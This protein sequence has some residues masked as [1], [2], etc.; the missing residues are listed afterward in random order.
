M[1]QITLYHV[2][3]ACSFV[4]HALLHHLGIAFKA[5]EMKFRA[6]DNGLE[7]ADGS[8]SN[9]EY[10]KINPAG[11]V[12]VL[13]VDG[14]L[15]TEQFAVLTMIALLAGDKA[16][17]EALLGGADPLARVRVVEWMA[18]L[19]DTL[20]SHGYGAF[21]H[22]QRFVE[23]RRDMYEV[24]KAKGLKTIEY[25]YALIE[26]RVADRTWAVGDHVTVVD[27]FLY[28]FWNWGGRLAGIDMGARYPAYGKLLRRVEA[29]EGVRKAMEEE[30]Q[31][32]YFE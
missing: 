15:V 28:V 3:A 2:N 25:S 20:H 11:Y 8:L 19:S 7:A 23:G 10:R 13:V 26:K 6:G 31:K 32:L 30:G 21:L 22:P 24:V 4:P 1:P 12:P 29:F 9:A 17:G 27:F 18:W 16:A 5:V 14:E